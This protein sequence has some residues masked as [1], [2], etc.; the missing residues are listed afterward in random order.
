MADP[1]QI[2]PYHADRL[3]REYYRATERTAKD[4]ADVKIVVEGIARTQVT[5]AEGVADHNNR[6]DHLESWRVH[7][8]NADEKIA[9]S[10]DTLVRAEERRSG[11]A[12]LIRA[13]FMLGLPT[14]VA[15]AGG[16]GW[17]I[18]HTR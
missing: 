12:S 17:L 3:I 11:Q 7:S 8:M 6:I 15:L 5:L 18:L 9:N 4:V 1:P 10:L 2:P 16:I 14:L 13:F